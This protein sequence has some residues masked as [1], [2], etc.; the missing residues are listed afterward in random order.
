METL[1]SINIII[2]VLAGVIALLLGFIAI[3][4]RKGSKNHTRSGSLFWKI[5]AIVIVTGLLGVFVF[6]R[7]TFLLVITLPSSKVM[8]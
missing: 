6:H 1:H 2:H 5:T 3:G 8:S 7:N 4:I